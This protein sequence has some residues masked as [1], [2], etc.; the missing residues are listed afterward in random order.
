MFEVAPAVSLAC[1]ILLL[2][3]L[4]AGSMQLS[5]QTHGIGIWAAVT[6]CTTSLLMLYYGIA[7]L[8]N[9][10]A[11]KEIL[12]IGQQIIIRP[13]RPKTNSTDDNAGDDHGTRA[14]RLHSS[15]HGLSDLFDSDDDASTTSNFQNED[16]YSTN[17]FVGNMTYPGDANLIGHSD[18]QTPLILML[19][20]IALYSLLVGCGMIFSSAI[21]PEA[22]VVALITQSA[23]L[24][25]CVA[26]GQTR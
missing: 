1:N 21:V 18:F 3:S 20:G 12:P 2:C 16:K 26:R 19:T 17:D 22:C 7:D 9:A 4:F 5:Y 6:F 13:H 8:A 15:L 10:I 23:V 14:I 24:L 25:I 11:Q